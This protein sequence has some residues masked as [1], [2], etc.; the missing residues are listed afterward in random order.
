VQSL[1]ENTDG[2]L[3]QQALQVTRQAIAKRRASTA[4]VCG[5]LGHVFY[6]SKVSVQSETSLGWPFS[7]SWRVTSYGCASSLDALHSVLAAQGAAVAHAGYAQRTTY[8]AFWGV[9]PTGS[10]SIRK[11]RRGATEKGWD[12]AS[13]DDMVSGGAIAVCG[14]GIGDE[15]A[16]GCGYFKQIC[17][18]PFLVEVYTSR[19]IFLLHS[20]QQMYFNIGANKCCFS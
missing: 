13:T 2:E 9:Y 14:R 4:I 1:A 20:D 12:W 5:I 6:M 15:T 8:R 11:A 18:L 7:S 17:S 16:A 19:H 10:K 3:P